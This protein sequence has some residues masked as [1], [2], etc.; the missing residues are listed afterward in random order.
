MS[1]NTMKNQ[2]VDIEYECIDKLENLPQDINL[3][4]MEDFFH[5]K[6]KPYHD[7][8]EDVRRGLLHALSNKDG[9][10]GFVLLARN[11][12]NGKIA[13]GLTMLNTGMKG[14]VPENLLLFVAVEP[15]LRGRGIGRKLIDNALERCSGGVKLHVEEQNPAR[16]LYARLGFE[17]KY[18]EMRRY[19]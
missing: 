11:R 3:K 19:G 1:E 10:S 17:E 6:M 4:D 5:T 8:R 18:V 13:G 2:S 12:N 9:N 16:N 7:E 14:Y 15:E